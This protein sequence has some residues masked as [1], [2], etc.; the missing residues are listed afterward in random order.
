MIVGWVEERRRGAVSHC[1]GRVPRHKGGS[2]VVRQYGLGV[3]PSGVTAERVSRHKGGSAVVR[4]YGLGVSPS[5]VTAER[6]PRHKATAVN[7]RQ[8]A[9]PEG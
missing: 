6:V 1:D 7:C 4:Q 2:A 9:Q 8:V 3:S 5:G